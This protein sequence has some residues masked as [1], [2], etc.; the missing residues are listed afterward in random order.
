MAATKTISPFDK[1]TIRVSRPFGSKA[2]GI[3]VNV[4]TH[5]FFVPFGKEHEVP[6]YIYEVLQNSMQQDER[7]AD[8]I[9]VMEGEYGNKSKE[10]GI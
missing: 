10:L 1:M 7:T 4:N 9:S 8:M 3:Y 6:R 5:N 2:K